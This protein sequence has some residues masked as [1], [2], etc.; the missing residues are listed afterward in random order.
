MLHVLA[1]CASAALVPSLHSFK[2][3]HA[4]LEEDVR[5]M[6]NRLEEQGLRNRVSTPHPSPIQRSP[7]QLPKSLS[8]Q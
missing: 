8:F 5:S 4:A 6:R 1:S 2:S 7:T 3:D